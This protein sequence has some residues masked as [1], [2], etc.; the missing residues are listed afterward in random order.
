MGDIP[1]QNRHFLVR[2]HNQR[3]FGPFVPG[4]TQFLQS[5]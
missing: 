2:G 5:F 1:S 4:Y 3:L